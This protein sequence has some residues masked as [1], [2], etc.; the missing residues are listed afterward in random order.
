MKEKVTKSVYDPFLRNPRY[1][2]VQASHTWELHA[3]RRHFH[4]TVALYASNLLKPDGASE[5]F[6]GDPLSDF[7]LIK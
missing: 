7:T 2:G 1:C 5:Q 3:L 6:S 4:P